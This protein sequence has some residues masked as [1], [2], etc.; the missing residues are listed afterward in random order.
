MKKRVWT[1]AVLCLAVVGLYG[2][3][4]ERQ[5]DLKVIV[6]KTFF[7]EQ[8]EPFYNI[9][10]MQAVAESNKQLDPTTLLEKFYAVMKEEATIQKF[11]APYS[12][13]TDEEI[14]EVRKI[15]EN[16]VYQKFSKEGV[17]VFQN[18]MASFKEI[19]QGILDR[20]GVEKAA[21][22]VAS[23]LL[24]ITQSN[25]QK[26][27]GESKKPLIVDVYSTT[28]GPCKMMEPILEELSQKYQEEIRFAKINCATEVELAKKYGVT[29]VPTLL[30]IKPGT[31][32]PAIRMVGYTSKKD[33]EAKIAEFLKEEQ[34]ASQ[35]QKR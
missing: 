35:N 5:Q 8:M 30:F 14:H 15:M 1:T 22:K 12:I 32:K 26:E 13:F 25:F 19:F 17:A 21:E 10:G 20:N 23:H 24:E 9:L 29:G 7:N 28:C 27:V 18:A 11:Y 6:Q 16:P 3:E 34:P 33:F 31:E 2:E 4:N